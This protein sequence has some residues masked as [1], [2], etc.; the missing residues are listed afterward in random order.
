[1]IATLR[2]RARRLAGR[3]TFHV[4]TVG[5]AVS[6]LFAL[7]L[8]AAAAPSTSSGYIAKVTNPSNSVNTAPYFTCA[9]AYGADKASSIFQYPLNE[10]TSLAGAADVGTTINLGTYRGAFAT[11]TATPLACS[12]DTGGAYVLDGSSSYVTSNLISVNPQTFSVEL[13]FKATVAGGKLIGLGSY[14]TGASNQ[15]DRHLYLDST[16]KLVF[17][18]ALNGTTIQVISTP[19]AVSLNAWHHAV[20]TMSAATGMK[21]YLDGSLVAANASYTT[22]AVYS[23]Y[24]HIGYDN[25]NGWPNPPAN[26]YF[27]GQMRWAAAYSVVLTATQVQTHWLA[28]R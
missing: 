4:V 10:V 14:L 17:G 11:S 26:Y 25:L 8:I 7:C 27:T 16:G 13:W 21:L 19:S 1:M 12:R 15:Y 23:G 6:S 22:A 3:R 28:G 20:G 2:S 18:T 24:W 9:G 5:L